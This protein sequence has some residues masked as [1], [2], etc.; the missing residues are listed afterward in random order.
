MRQRIRIAEVV[1][2]NVAEVDPSE[3]VAV[4]PNPIK[5]TTLA[6]L[7]GQV[8]VSKVVAFTS[9]TLPAVAESASVP[10]TSGVGRFT[11]PAAPCD[12]WIRKYSPGCSAPSNSWPAKSSPQRSNI[13]R[14]SQ[15]AAAP[16]HPYSKSR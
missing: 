6:L 14:S 3:Q 16:T 7:V 2:V 4:E 8:P 13:A 12:F 9:A 15:P 11:V 1:L 5:S 10:V